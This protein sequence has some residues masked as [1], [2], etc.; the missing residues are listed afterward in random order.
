MAHSR[1][2]GDDRRPNCA[3]VERPS[4]TEFIRGEASAVLVRS[5]ETPKIAYQDNL[6]RDRWKAVVPEIVFRRSL[7]M[8]DHRMRSA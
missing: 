7:Q 2:R 8:S 4:G 1:Q 5:R 6:Q 3:E